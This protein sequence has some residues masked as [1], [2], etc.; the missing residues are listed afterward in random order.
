MIWDKSFDYF[1]LLDDGYRCI[2]VKMCA[3]VVMF[4]LRRC[5]RGAYA[6]SNRNSNRNQRVS[7]QTIY[8]ECLVENITRFMC[9]CRSVCVI[10]VKIFSA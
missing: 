3:V 4:E 6:I 10:D 2:T 1:L 8:C 9:V 7:A 5:E